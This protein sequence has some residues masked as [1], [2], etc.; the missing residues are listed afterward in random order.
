MG[1]DSGLRRARGTGLKLVVTPTSLYELGIKQ[2]GDVVE[3]FG[4]ARGALLN[5][6]ILRRG[7]PYVVLVRDGNLEGIIDRMDL[8]SRM[9]SAALQ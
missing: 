4:E 2:Q 6:E 3:Q 5:S 8:A 9:A 7:A 1:I